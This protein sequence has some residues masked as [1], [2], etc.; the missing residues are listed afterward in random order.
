V[1]AHFTRRR[2][3]YVTAGGL[4]PVYATSYLN[5]QLIENK[6]E[7]FGAGFGFDPAARVALSECA[8]TAAAHVIQK[9]DFLSAHLR[10]KLLRDLHTHVP[11]L[12]ASAFDVFSESRPARV[13]K[14]AE[15]V[16]SSLAL[17]RVRD[18]LGGPQ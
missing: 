8:L 10:V 12:V 17:A 7:I 18:I 3:L 9:C 1:Y 5:M 13:R 14:E 16:R 6:L 11:P 2:E 15:I 4:I